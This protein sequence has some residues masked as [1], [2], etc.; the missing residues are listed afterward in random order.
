MKN[1]YHTRPP[2]PGPEC[3]SF[4]PLLALVGQELLHPHDASELRAHL[5]TCDYC[6]TELE[7][8]HWLDDALRRHF[9]PPARLP[10][11]HRDIVHMV[12]DEGVQR[13]RRSAA[14]A[15]S[16]P[17]HAEHP[18]SLPLP[19]RGRP[20]QRPVRR[21]P[22]HL[23]SFISAI[24][25]VLIIALVGVALV[26]SH[27]PAQPGRNPH[28]KAGSVYAPQSGD[29]LRSISMISTH[30]GWAVGNRSA[31]QGDGEMLILHYN[32]EHWEMVSGPTN[33]ALQ[34]TSSDLSRVSL[35][36]A[37]EGWAIGNLSSPSAQAPLTAAILHYT[38]G[39]WSL[40]ATIP[41]VVLSDLAMVSASDGWAVGATS[42]SRDSGQ[43]G[44]L[45]H[46]TEG[47]W[48]RVSAFGITLDRVVMLSSKDGW[49]VGTSQAGS[50][51][52]HYNGSTWTPVTIPVLDNV[53]QLAMISA[54]DG[55]A[56]GSK[57]LTSGSSNARSSGRAVKNVFAHYNGKTW[58]EVP[59]AIMD[60]QSAIV[61][62]LA[63]DS[64]TDGWAVGFVPGDPGANVLP[65][66]LYLHYT[67]GQWLQVDGPGM[68][69]L[70]AVS[71]LSASEGWAVGMRGI[72]M[73]YLNGRWSMVLGAPSPTPTG[74]TVNGTPVT[75]PCSSQSTPS[76]PPGAAMTP[77]PLASWRIYTNTTYHYTL[78]YPSNWVVENINCPDASYLAFWNYNAQGWM[79][80]GFPSGGIKIELYALEN[81]SDLSA[82]DFFKKEEHGQELTTGPA[83]PS[84]TIRT[85]S[86]AGRDAVEAICSG[87]NTDAYYIPDG[88][89]MLRIGQW[90]DPQG[91]ASDVLAQMVASLT[92]T[93]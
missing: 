17:L 12:D 46:Y 75:P 79:G 44:V 18:R 15:G 45:L 7:A 92:F 38:G 86:V 53:Y 68:D 36:S 37:T 14:F 9:G 66:N 21:R 41:N 85:L 48:K 47:V 90:K 30:D 63:M 13:S 33:Q 51:L 93:T 78:K 72:I 69:G 81:P 77:V 23:I 39:R 54:S 3:A 91:P 26:I 8:Y 67:G 71:L 28:P 57:Y 74:P 29:T 50:T 84:Y 87:L 49:I 40:Q 61:N 43:Q 34:A 65:R 64:P 31:G 88:K 1:T 10:L 80:P 4:A 55:W 70:N 59:T 35:V 25:A 22:R 52:W 16:E 83:C 19:P 11:S 20:P 6:R 24:A 82:M 2:M 89:T 27:A 60:N 56:F 58:T 73:H 42:Y 32:G 76:G 62:A 5:A